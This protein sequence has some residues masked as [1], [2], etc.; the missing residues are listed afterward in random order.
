ME[1][2]IIAS[3]QFP[4]AIWVAGG[5]APVIGNRFLLEGFED[6]LIGSKASEKLKSYFPD[7]LQFL[8]GNVNRDDVH[9]VLEYKVGE[10]WGNFTVKR[11]NRFIVHS[12]QNN[13]YINSLEDFEDAIK[14]K[15]PRLV[16]ASA[17]QMLDMFPFEDI[18][19]RE[20]RMTKLKSL[21]QNTPKST[22]LHF[23][24]ASFIEIDMMKSVLENVMPY[25]DSFGMNEQELPN[26]LSMLRHGNI[27]EVADSNPRTATVLDGMRELYRYYRTN[28]H[29]EVSRIHVHTLAFQ[30]ILV[31]KGSQWKDNRAAAAKA[32]LVALRHVCNVSD[33]NIT[34]TKLI[35]DDSF[36]LTASSENNER[37]Y[38]NEDLPI[39]CWEE[40]DYEICIS[41]VLVCTAVKQ[42]AGG[43]DNISAAGIMVQI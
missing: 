34:N 21:F 35:M 23:E 3:K 28:S 5:N 27:I 9:L 39:S 1:E 25:V 15:Q 17:L 37:V 16:I 41:P 12:D 18:E 42:T 4:D 11:A 30:A 14:K 24:M 31:K 40:Q 7:K 19:I 13:P 38:F 8:E 22:L 36:S 43:G 32:S 33:V 2:L 10:Q 26:I 29:R 6:V 20:R